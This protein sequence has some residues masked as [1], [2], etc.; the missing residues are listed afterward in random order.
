MN[1]IKK[2]SF[3]AF[4]FGSLI[5]WLCILWALFTLIIS[6]SDVILFADAVSFNE[7]QTCST[8]RDTSSGSKHIPLNTF[9]VISIEDLEFSASL[10]FAINQVFS[11][12]FA[13]AFLRNDIKDSVFGARWDESADSFIVGIRIFVT[14]ADVFAVDKFMVGIN[15]TD[16]SVTSFSIGIPEVVFVTDASRSIGGS[17]WVCWA[18]PADAIDF[19]CSWFA[20]TFLIFPDFVDWTSEDTVSKH[21]HV[22]RS[23]LASPINKNFIEFAVRD[24]SFIFD[25]FIRAADHTQIS[26]NLSSFLSAPFFGCALI[27]A[28]RSFTINPTSIK[29][30]HWDLS[31]SWFEPTSPGEN[32]VVFDG[33]VGWESSCIINDV[34]EVKIRNERNGIRP[35]VQGKISSLSII[36][37]VAEIEIKTII[38]RADTRDKDTDFIRLAEGNFSDIVGDSNP[39]LI[40]ASTAIKRV[41]VDI[42]RSSWKVS[43]WCC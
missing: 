35:D 27:F 31:L 29:G 3:N 24:A 43:P 36:F 7:F 40:S 17:D 11:F 33:V 30:A 21:F 16:N 41:Q 38:V 2:I 9:A 37:N 13:N 10:T 42:E 25:L 8:F 18:V 26:I 6:D 19:G 39:L 12:D 28:A 22:A 15:S 20:D 5:V 1:S 34:A 32:I 4:T 14:L 23:A